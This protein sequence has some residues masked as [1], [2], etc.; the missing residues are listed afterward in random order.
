MGNNLTLNI[1]GEN[2]E[3]LKTYETQHVRWRIF[4][5][6]LKLN[7]QIKDKGADEQLA[8]IGEFVKKIFIGLT[9]EELQLADAF[10][11]FNTFKIIVNKANLIR[12][13]AA[14]NA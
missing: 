14:K 13:S 3:I 7:E 8:A 9:D 6:A 4:G 11:V 5:D 10:D 1:Y 2:D 12:G